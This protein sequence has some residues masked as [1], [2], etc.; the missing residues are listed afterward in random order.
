MDTKI[1][2]YMEKYSAHFVDKRLFLSEV[3]VLCNDLLRGKKDVQLWLKKSMKRLNYWPQLVKSCL[4]GPPRLPKNILPALRYTCPWILPELQVRVFSLTRPHIL[5]AC[6][7]LTHIWNIW[8]MKIKI[9]VWSS[10]RLDKYIYLG[11]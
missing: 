3:E 6:L 1:V 4:L 11:P 9:K 10:T 5:P 8:I 2:K 7:N